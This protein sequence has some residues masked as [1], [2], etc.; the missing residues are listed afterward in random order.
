MFIDCYKYS[1]IMNEK[2]TCKYACGF[3]LISGISSES[4]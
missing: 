1:I 2:L 3:E 4:E